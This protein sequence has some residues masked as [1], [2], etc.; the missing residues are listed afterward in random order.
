MTWPW[1]G[2]T[3]HRA[4]EFA[5]ARDKAEVDAMAMRHRAART[6]AEQAVDA[7]DCSRL[8]SMLGLDD[9]ARSK[10]QAQLS[11]PVWTTSARASRPPA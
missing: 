4:G 7:A 10:R 9:V 5:R 2:V 6:V 8:L 3:L 11:Q 1:Q